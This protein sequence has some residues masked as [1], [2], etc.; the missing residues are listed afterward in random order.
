MKIKVVTYVSLLI[1]GLT[2][3]CTPKMYFTNVDPNYKPIRVAALDEPALNKDEAAIEET[4]QALEA[5]TATPSKKITTQEVKKEVEPS[6]VILEEMENEIAN[7]HEKPEE[8]ETINVDEYYKPLPP[9]KEF[10]PISVEKPSIRPNPLPKPEANLD[11]DLDFD[12]ELFEQKKNKIDILFVIDN[13][14]SMQR[15]QK[16]LGERL[17]S[18][19]KGIRHMDWQI[20]FTTSDVSNGKHGIKG[21]LLDLSGHPNKKVLTP[22]H[23][24]A[25]NVFYSTVQRPEAQ[26]CIFGCPSSNEQP[27]RASIMAMEKSNTVNAEFFRED[28]DLSIVVLT[29]EDE[30]STGSSKKTTTANQ[31]VDSFHSIFGNDKKLSVYG[32]VIEPNDV[33]CYEAQKS[34]GI[35]NASPGLSVANLSRMTDGYIGSIC[36]N[37]YAIALE[38]ISE[39]T[40]LASDFFQLKRIPIA[41]SV[42][43]KLVP[44]QDIP[45]TIKG[46]RLTFSTPPK[47]GTLVQVSY[48]YQNLDTRSVNR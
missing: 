27:L 29:D 39:E 26:N 15:E 10:R 28:A 33:A 6:P 30:M 5:P 31:V 38:K 8:V 4:I 24:D 12:T 21:S 42:K 22:D 25:E 11:N 40:R 19:L 16:K 48:G 44:E 20:A 9:K 34:E 13:S 46:D 1:I 36:E 23:Q 32:I 35:N 2:I 14:P 18:F 17:Q 3:S 41:N 43:V 45:W 47:Q 37:D 7:I